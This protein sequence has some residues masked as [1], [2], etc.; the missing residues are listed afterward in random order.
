MI[1]T[2]PFHKRTNALNETGL[3]SHWSGQLAAHRYQISDKFEYFAVRNAAGVFDSSPLYKYRIRG[4][5][6]ERFLSGILARDIRACPP[7]HAQY[8][9]WCDDR[10]FVIEDG[11]VLRPAADEFLLTAAEPNLA[12]FEDL[13]G[14]RDRVAI[15]DVSDDYGILAVQGP[16]SR[17]L[18]SA[19]VPEVAHIPF[20]G[21]T[22]GKIAGSPVIVSRTGYSGDLGYEVWVRSGDAV[23][24]WDALWGSMDGFGVLPF[25]LDALDMLRIEAGLLLLDVDFASSRFGWTDEDRSSLIE[26]G[27]GWMVRN[28][29]TDDR[30][31]IGR[32]A[33]ER[34]IADAT[35]RWRLTGLVVDWADYDRIYSAAGLIPPKDHTPVLGEMFLYDEGGTQ[36][37]YTTSYMYSPMLQRHIAL[38]RV[39]PAL[40]APGSPVRLEIDVNH[41]YEYVAA[42]TA[43]LPLYNP[44]RKTA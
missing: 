1:R 11:V 42:R 44:T 9:A 26:L 16:R 40:A 22:T 8:T 23:K 33:I 4:E 41:R 31:F 17:D 38:A 19:L 5:D 25:G 24:V 21:L 12:Y 3:W 35:S 28:L 36:V 13:I 10:G 43:R 34:E 20:F 15:E 29:A 7:G 6:A 32:R 2:T 27:W 18:L 37:G 14:R 39:R 30:A